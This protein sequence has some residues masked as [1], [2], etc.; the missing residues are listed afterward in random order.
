MKILINKLL[1]VLVFLAFWAFLY[2]ICSYN[3]GVITFILACL[4]FSMVGKGDILFLAKD[5]DR[6]HNHL[7]GMIENLQHEVKLLSSDY[8]DLRSELNDTQAELDSLRFPK[9][10]IDF[11]DF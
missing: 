3:F 8:D 6:N 5:F 2:W 1:R 4:I 11:D 9:N 7:V 10:S